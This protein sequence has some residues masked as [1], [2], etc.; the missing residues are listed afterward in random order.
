MKKETRNQLSTSIPLSWLSDLFRHEQT[1]FLL[2]A[3]TTTWP[4]PPWW[5]V[6]TLMLWARTH[7]SSFKLLLAGHLITAMRKKT[8][9]L[10]GSPESQCQQAF[11]SNFVGQLRLKYIT[12]SLRTILVVPTYCWVQFRFLSHTRATAFQS[13]YKGYWNLSRYVWM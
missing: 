7:H 6:C 8:N 1:A 10:S 5:T 9:G 13:P 3:T 4:S 11:A 2:K 12:S